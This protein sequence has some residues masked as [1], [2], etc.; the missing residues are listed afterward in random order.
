MYVCICHSVTDRDILQAADKGAASL[1]DLSE[2]L[3]VATC[4]GRCADCAKN[5]LKEA[6]NN[7]V[8]IELPMMMAVTA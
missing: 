6:R 4:C 8:T 5:L 1:Q 2:E 3:N 7:P